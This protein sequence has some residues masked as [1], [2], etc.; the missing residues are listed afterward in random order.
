MTKIIEP[1]EI[2]QIVPSHRWGGCFAVV[3]EVKTW[4][5][6]AYVAVP[7]SNEAPGQAYIRL[8]WDEF[9]RVGASVIFVPD[10]GM[11]GD[12]EDPVP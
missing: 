12:D 1:L 5:V 9:E 8:T 11:S 6:Q 3:S 7:N 4:G 10:D 2:V